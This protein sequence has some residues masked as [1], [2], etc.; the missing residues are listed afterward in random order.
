M[1]RKIIGFMTATP[2]TIYS[3]RLARGV[4]ARCADYDYDVAVIA[5]LADISLSQKNYL[6]GEINIYNL[7]NFDIL[8]GVIVDTLSLMDSASRQLIPEIPRLLKEKC[9]KPIVC[10]GP[11]LPEYPTFITRN[12]HLLKE[13]T[14]HVIDTHQCRDL[15]CLTGPKGDADATDRLQGFAE[16]LADRGIPYDEANVFYGDFW[17][18]GGAELG[19]K[20]VSGEVHRP[21]AVV[22][23][24]DHMAIGLT[25]YLVQHGVRVPED[26]IVT[27]FDAT[28][29]GIVNQ[30]TIS[31]ST[32]DT[33]D[34][35]MQAVDELRLL[36]SPG[37][38]IAPCAPYRTGTH[39]ALGMSCGCSHD[40]PNIMAQMRESIYSISM[41]NTNSTNTV[42]IGTLLDSNM[43]EYLSDTATPQDCI[44]QIFMKT[45][46]LSPYQDFYLCLD[47]NWLNAELCCKTGYPARIKM[48]VHTTPKPDSGHCQNGPM[49]DTSIMLPDLL[50]QEREASVFYFMPVHF[51][52]QSMGYAVLRYA[53]SE[54]HKF[55]CIIRNWLKNVNSGLHIS[56]TT[57]R[58]E[59]LSTRDGM[60]S[61]YNRRGMELMLDQMLRRA[62]PDDSVLAF[63]IDMDRLK[64]INDTFGHADGDFGINAICSAAN[65]ITKEGELCV[66]A[67]G[68]EFYVVGIGQYDLSEAEQRIARFQ[69]AIDQLNATLH[70]PYPLSASIGSACIPLSSGMTVMGVIRIADAKMYEN[71]VQK[72]I[73]RKD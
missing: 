7:I 9:R 17:Y 2:E 26:V 72:K 11:L 46:L 13:L 60:T 61:A 33:E 35:S 55:T 56:R 49:F 65:S 47:E 25:N 71:K 73:Q 19:R 48:V 43:T 42:D 62:K 22:C 54:P 20:I 39:L 58:L 15:Y 69:Q 36:M 52:D 68:D 59:S 6:A 44:E 66:R 1:A 30:V 40:V 45:Y 4:F 63:V 27:G 3:S 16:A 41:D 18:P 5:T 14:E 38:S 24:S 67:G 28:P 8:D 64:Y 10:L 32:P 50:N 23:A 31:S 12:H 21:Q 70:K 37:A 57:H 53:L 29:E 34:V 51:L